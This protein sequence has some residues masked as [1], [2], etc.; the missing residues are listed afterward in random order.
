MPCHNRRKPACSAPKAEM[1]CAF[2]VVFRALNAPLSEYDFG[3]LNQNQGARWS[4]VWYPIDISELTF[5]FGAFFI[6]PLPH[7]FP[8]QIE[9]D[10]E[11]VAC[12][13]Q[14]SWLLL[15]LRVA[16]VQFPAAAILLVWGKGTCE[17]WDLTA[18]KHPKH[19]CVTNIRVTLDCDHQIIVKTSSVDY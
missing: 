4:V 11:G 12:T 17:A 2:D 8:C 10:A 3:Y 18:A 6:L 13:Y 14:R 5:R 1:Q 16:Q 19:P 9:S 15:V 7:L